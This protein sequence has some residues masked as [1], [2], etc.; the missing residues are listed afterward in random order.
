MTPPLEGTS[1]SKKLQYDMSDRG[2]GALRALTIE[3]PQQREKVENCISQRLFARVP[4]CGPGKKAAPAP[5]SR[6]NEQYVKFI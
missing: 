6:D 1:L 2:E 4:P 3:L 5:L